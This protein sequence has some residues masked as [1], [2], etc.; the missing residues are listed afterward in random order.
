MRFYKTSYTDLSISQ[1]SA[2]RGDASETFAF[3]HFFPDSF[4]SPVA[5]VTDG[6]FDLLVVI[7]VCTP[8]SDMDIEAGNLRAAQSGG[9]DAFF[10]G[11]GSVGGSNRISAARQ[12]AERR[13]AL[14]LKALDQRLHAVSTNGRSSTPSGG[15]GTNTPGNHEMLG[16]TSLTPERDD[17]GL[18]RAGN[19]PQ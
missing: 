19:G 1:S 4:Q 18:G 17:D 5:V 3:S 9:G 10:G 12:E 2:L 8:F 16:N 14:A 13:R 15:S 7:K 11:G 6:V